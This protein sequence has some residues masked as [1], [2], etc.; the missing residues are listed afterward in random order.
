MSERI[1]ITLTDSA[2]I[3]AT[4]AVGSISMYLIAEN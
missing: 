2:L 1:R 4:L 3:V